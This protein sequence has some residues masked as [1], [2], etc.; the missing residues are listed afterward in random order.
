MSERVNV[1]K[2]APVVI[3]LVLLAFVMIGILV[4]QFLFNKEMAVLYEEIGQMTKLTESF[5]LTIV[6]FVALLGI[7]ICTHLDQALVFD[8]YGLFTV[9]YVALHI[10]LVVSGIWACSTSSQGLLKLTN[11]NAKI[12]VTGPNSLF[13][14]CGFFVLYLGI[15]NKKYHEEMNPFLYYFLFPVLIFVGCFVATF[16]I[17]KIPLE[18][19]ASIIFWVLFLAS[20]IV[21]GILILIYSNFGPDLGAKNSNDHYSSNYAAHYSSSYQGL[22]EQE[23]NDRI[24]RELEDAIKDSF[25]HVFVSGLNDFYEECKF[26]DVDVS[27]RDG[28]CYMYAHIFYDL[29]KYGSMTSQEAHDWAENFTAHIKEE[30][31]NQAQRVIRDYH[32]ILVDSFKIDLTYEYE[33]NL[34]D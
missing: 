32:H 3:S 25:R 2:P 10:V 14:I 21:G 27:I 30:I 9:I 22:S 16:F 6:F 23:K 29:S 24:T 26:S 19:L 31:C 7:L 34:K 18:L 11:Q 1:E 17:F 5:I 15:F 8:E 13:L 20:F 4:L 28:V 33:Y 12:C